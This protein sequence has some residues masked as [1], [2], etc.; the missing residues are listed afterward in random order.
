MKQVVGKEKPAL[1]RAK[2]TM[3][4]GYSSLFT[5]QTK[6]VWDMRLSRFVYYFGGGGV[7]TYH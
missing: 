5:T 1:M 3:K 2:T 4:L 7:Q 6:I